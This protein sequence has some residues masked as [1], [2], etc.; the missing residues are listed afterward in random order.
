MHPK[1]LQIRKKPLRK[2]VLDFNSATITELATKL[3]KG[4]STKIGGLKVV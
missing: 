3:L 1:W 2:R 4:L